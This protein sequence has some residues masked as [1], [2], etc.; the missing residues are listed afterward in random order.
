M[1][2]EADLADI[3]QQGYLEMAIKAARGAPLDV[4][5]PEN[6]CWFCESETG[7]EKRWCDAECRDNWEREQWR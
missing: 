2:D 5:N 4:S 1:S 6:V 7:P 3:Q